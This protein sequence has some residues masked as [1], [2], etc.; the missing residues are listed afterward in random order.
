MAG[1]PDN[2]KPHEL[3]DRARPVM[4]RQTDARQ[5]RVVATS[6]LVDFKDAMNDAEARL[7]TQFTE[8]V[9]R[10]RS[11]NNREFSGRPQNL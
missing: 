7:I 4:Q 5:P 3:L 2:L 6:S 1:S 8:R 9:G 11:R 10:R